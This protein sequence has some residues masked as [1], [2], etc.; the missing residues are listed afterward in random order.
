MVAPGLNVRVLAVA[1]QLLGPVVALGRGGVEGSPPEELA[2][3]LAP[4][5]GD[6]GALLIDASPLAVDGIPPAG[7]LA[8]EILLG[9]VATLVADHPEL[10]EVRLDPLLVSDSAVVTDLRV[11]FEPPAPSAFPLVRRI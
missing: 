8:L 11:T 2:V 5:E 9:R 3:R 10:V 4:L 1:D 7:R 6:D